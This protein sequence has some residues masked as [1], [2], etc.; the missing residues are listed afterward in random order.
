MYSNTHLKSRETLPLSFN[1]EDKS[2][3]VPTVIFKRGNVCYECRLYLKASWTLDVLQSFGWRSGA[4]SYLRTLTELRY[5]FMA[6]SVFT[7]SRVHI[8]FVQ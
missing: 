1:E 4:P 5:G 6:V 8:L 2:V 7:A 3:T